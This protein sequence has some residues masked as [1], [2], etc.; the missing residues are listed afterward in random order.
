M[1]SIKYPN[2]MQ[3]GLCLRRNYF[4]KNQF[5]IY[6][7]GTKKRKKINHLLTELKFALNIKPPHSY[8]A[9]RVLIIVKDINKGILYQSCFLKSK[10]SLKAERESAFSGLSYP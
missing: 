4:V 7:G 3:S 2:V 10:N 9:T 8:F 6:T 5:I 1:T